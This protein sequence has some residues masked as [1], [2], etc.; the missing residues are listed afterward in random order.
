MFLCCTELVVPIARATAKAESN[1]MLWPPPIAKAGNGAGSLCFP[2]LLKLRMLR[3][4]VAKL[5]KEPWHSSRN[6]RRHTTSRT[7]CCPSCCCGGQVF[8]LLGCK[9]RLFWSGRLTT[10]CEISTLN[11][12]AGWQAHTKHHKDVGWQTPYPKTKGR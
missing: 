7:A 8:G 12:C 5:W 1:W 3:D 6:A 2:T 10:T 11:L 9:L 4:S